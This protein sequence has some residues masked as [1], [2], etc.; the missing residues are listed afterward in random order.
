MK[1][2]LG[3][4]LLFTLSLVSAWTL[5]ASQYK[6]VKPP[7]TLPEFSM[8]DQYGEKFGLD[9]LKGH[10][11]IIFVGFTTCPDVCPFT[12]ANLEAVRADLSLRVRPDRLPRVIFLAVDPDRD[13][14]VLG[15]YLEY[16]HPNYIGITG[17][18]EQID[19]LIKGLGSFYRL[20]KR[21]ADDMNYDV[22]H[23][24]TVYITNPQA[25]VVA[26]MNPP[27]DPVATGEYLF[28]IIRGVKFN[29]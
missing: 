26:E 27:F 14:A 25:E 3:F 11:S 10:W 16:F 7:K 21:G 12:L 9:A 4:T 1:V 6:Q 18:K 23:A 17:E 8:E 2:S 5:G 19:T 20:A 28:N 15:E 24:A 22:V 29:D 13:R